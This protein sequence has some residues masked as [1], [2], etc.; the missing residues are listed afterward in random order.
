M[1][2]CV[3]VDDDTTTVRGKHNN[4]FITVCE[5]TGVLDLVKHRGGPCDELR[6]EGKPSCEQLFS[7]LKK[8]KSH[9]VPSIIPLLAVMRGSC[10]RALFFLMRSEM[11]GK[12][13]TPYA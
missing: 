8:G 9:H 2:E 11:E 5:G 12:T 3:C 7:H 6:E 4:Q 13:L 10:V 1:R